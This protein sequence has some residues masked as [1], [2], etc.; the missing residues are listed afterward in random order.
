[1]KKDFSKQFTKCPCCGCEDRFLEQ[2]G[3]ELKDR[4]LARQDWDFHMDVRQGVVLDQTKADAIP[5]GSEVPGY[6]LKTDICMGCG[7]I[8]AIDIVRSDVKKSIA[9]AQI[10][11]PNRT[12]R[13]RDSREGEQPFSLS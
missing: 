13:R 6:G 10:V 11:P 7:C 4:G 5:I 2:L 9:P 12:Q 3:D 1:M 8:Y